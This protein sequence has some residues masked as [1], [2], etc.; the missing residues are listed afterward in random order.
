MTALSHKPLFVESNA[1][2][3]AIDPWSIDFLKFEELHLV[4]GILSLN[5]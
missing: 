3:S 5:S 4:V 1:Q 2:Y